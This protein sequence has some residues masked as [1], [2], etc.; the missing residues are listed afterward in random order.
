MLLCKALKCR[1]NETMCFLA[2]GMYGI[3]SKALAPHGLQMC[4]VGGVARGHINRLKHICILSGNSLTFSFQTELCEVFRY[5]RNYENKYKL[6]RLG[7]SSFLSHWKISSTTGFP[8]STSLL[9][10]QKAFWSIIKFV[11]FLAKRIE[12]SY[13]V[14]WE[15]LTLSFHLEPCYDSSQFF[16]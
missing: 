15:V 16:L 11:L 12:I 9:L 2:A 8:I 10:M 1:I 13:S 4:V 6:D 14:L 7:T 5:I 3:G